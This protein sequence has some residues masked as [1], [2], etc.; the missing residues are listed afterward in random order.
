LNGQDKMGPMPSLA[1]DPAGVAPDHRRRREQ[2]AMGSRKKPK[3]I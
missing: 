2:L 1:Q 3:Q